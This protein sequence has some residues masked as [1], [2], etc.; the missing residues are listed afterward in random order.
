MERERLDDQ[1]AFIDLRRAARSSRPKPT[2]HNGGKVVGLA[3]ARMGGPSR[4]EPL[5]AGPRS[6]TWGPWTARSPPSWNETPGADGIGHKLS[7]LLLGF[8]ATE[9]VPLAD[10]LAELGID[11]TPLFAA[12]SG[13]LRL[14][15]DTLEHPDPRR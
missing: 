5:T 4:P 7:Q 12:T 6:W 8:L 15:A 11:P 10:R 14:Y 13:I 2:N 1:Q 9:V 3:P